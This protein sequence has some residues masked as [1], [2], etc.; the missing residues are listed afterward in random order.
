M[1]KQI[2]GGKKADPIEVVEAK[3][4]CELNL[5]SDGKWMRLV[6]EGKQVAAFHIEYVQKVLSSAEKST[7]SKKSAP[8]REVPASI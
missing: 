5:S 7:K 8:H 6:V 3:D 1:K 2:A 4:G